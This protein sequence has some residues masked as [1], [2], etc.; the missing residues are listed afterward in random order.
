MSLD[1]DDTP[2]KTDSLVL[3]SDEEANVPIIWDKNV[4]SILVSNAQ[5][6]IQLI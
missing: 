5:K 2:P 1:Y 3:Y 6:T 4:A